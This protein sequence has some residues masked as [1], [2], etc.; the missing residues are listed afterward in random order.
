MINETPEQRGKRALERAVA[1]GVREFAAER[2]DLEGDFSS[3]SDPVI[4]VP[5]HH[6]TNRRYISSA[7]VLRQIATL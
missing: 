6:L 4:P 1:L 3:F 5:Y 7:E 2:N